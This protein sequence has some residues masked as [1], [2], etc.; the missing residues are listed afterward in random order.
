MTFY[1]FIKPYRKRIA[2]A[3]FFILIANLLS[4]ALPWSIKIII[5]DV[6]INK[7]V[8]LLNIIIFALVGILILQLGFNFLRKMISNMIG[9]KIVCDLREKIYWHAQKMPLISIKKITPSQILTRIT[10]DVES[11]R[12]FIFSD[13]IDFIYAIL[14]LGF[15]T[16]ILLWINP[17]LTLVA[18]LTLPIFSIMYFRIL[19]RLKSGYKSLRD[20]NAKL[21]SRVN[22]VL[23][24]MAIVRIFTAEDHEK[25]KFTARQNEI[26]NIAKKN[27][28]LNLSLWTAIDFFTTV[29]VIGV[30]W[31]GGLDVIYKRMTPGELIAFYSYLGMLFTPLIRMVVINSSYQEATAALCRINE[32]MG[33]GDEVEE[34]QAPFV[35]VA[36]KGQVEFRNVSFCYSQG[37]CVLKDINFSVKEGENIGIVGPSGA[38]KTTLMNLLIRFIDPQKGEIY[39]DGNN[40]KNLELGFYRR[41]LAIVLQD[42][43]I[44][45]GTI[46]DNICYGS[47]NA[48]FE[49]IR[50]AAEIAQADEFINGLK[51]GYMTQVG[52]RGTLLSCGQRQ[53]IAI[54]RAI[55]RKPSILILDEATSSLDAITENKIQG[56]VRQY[57]KDKTVLIVAHR[58]S[59]IMEADKII[60]ID[61]GKIIE[62][63]GHN[64]LLKRQGFYSSLYYEQFKNEDP[65]LSVKAEN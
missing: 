50:K 52:D 28:S 13:A 25:N 18:L 36:I 6:L 48:S 27:H 14:S 65:Y 35:P 44:F 4:L 1:S 34:V 39:I 7:N 15:I 63:G 60:V 53:R 9:E 47:F 40:L 51:D 55:L 37:N 43:Y 8:Q 38:G 24:G 3:L 19:P 46:K 49:E 42:D 41:N 11:V 45:S 16:I 61:D 26:M 5:D 33:C 17:R 56:A 54:A 20:V 58:F 30:L 59:S 23:S 32:I 64:Y 29:G 12:R 10:G 57:M 2:L 62:A 21:A 31:I 22:E